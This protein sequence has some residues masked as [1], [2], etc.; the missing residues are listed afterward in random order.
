MVWKAIAYGLVVLNCVFIACELGQRLS[1]S[2]AE[3]EDIFDQFDWYLLPIGVQ[4]LLLIVIVNAQQP[5]VIKCFG[6]I[7]G[8]R[9][10]FKKVCSTDQFDFSQLKTQLK[11]GKFFLGDQC[12]I[13]IL[14]GSSQI[15]QLNAR[16][17]CYDDDK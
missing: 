17:T 5:V 10:Q 15:V 8:S 6:N 4:R 14:Y 3:I 16:I 2:F 12:S 13:S 9:E 1:N 11:I 7:S